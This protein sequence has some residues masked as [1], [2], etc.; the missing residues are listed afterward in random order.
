MGTIAIQ[1]IPYHNT[2][3]LI[4]PFFC[5]NLPKMGLDRNEDETITANGC[6]FMGILRTYVVTGHSIMKVL[7][8]V[9][10]VSHSFAGLQIS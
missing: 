8:S 9:V 5:Q 7:W 2:V 1:A 10:V 4:A 6:N 3:F